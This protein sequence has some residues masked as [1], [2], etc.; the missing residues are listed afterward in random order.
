MIRY[1]L[2]KLVEWAGTL[3]SHKR[4]QKVLFLLQA[5]GYPVNADYSL[6]LSGPYSEEIAQLS[7]DMVQAG[8]LKQVPRLNAAGL[9]RAYRLT[10][11][12]IREISEFEGTPKGKKLAKQLSS[13]AKRAKQL[14]D[15]DI[16]ILDVASTIVYFRQ[17]G[18]S[19]PIS[20]DK[21]CKFK[22]LVANSSVVMEAE[23]LAH[24]FVA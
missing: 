7:D 24:D 17:Q 21:T 6:H 5:S 1:Q 23:G 12:A 2:A 18:C 4:L 8:V 14:L 11:R 13:F 20:I 16:R 22:D 15:T 19:W 10:P 9:W 3:D